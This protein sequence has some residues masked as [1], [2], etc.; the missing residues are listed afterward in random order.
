VTVVGLGRSGVAAATL[1]CRVGARVRATDARETDAL[2]ATRTG[3]SQLGVDAVELGGH[4][5][6]FVDDADVLVVSPG[7]PDSAGPIQQATARGTPIVSEIELAFQFCRS[8]VIAVTGTNGKSTV[9]SLI[10]AVLRAAGRPA[11]ACGNLGNPFSSVV[12]NPL[13]S[14]TVVVVEVSS[15]QLSRCVQFRP[16]VGVLL[17]I[18]ANH[19][20]RHQDADTY[21]AAKAKLFERQTP[22]DWAVLNGSDPRCVVLGERIRAQ[23][24]WFGT[25]RA[26]PPAFRLASA[27]QRALPENAQA[28]LQVGRLL[29]I[30]DPLIWQVIRAFR[31]LEHRLECVATIRGVRFVNDS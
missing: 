27:T 12:I 26:N 1:L 15:F 17:N 16:K 2:R 22:E 20:D 3:L 31:G 7:V 11:I 10:A 21:V 23:R 30:P 9:V 13:G 24:V 5:P 28:V 6:R 19:L 29:G 25:D 14:Q 8:P 18:G 4:S